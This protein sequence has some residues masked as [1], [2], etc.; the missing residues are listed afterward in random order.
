MELVYVDCAAPICIL[1]SSLTP[2][3]HLQLIVCSLSLTK[4]CCFN[5][6]SH[7]GR[8]TSRKCYA[9]S[10]LISSECNGPRLH[11]THSIC[12]ALSSLLEPCNNTEPPWH[13]SL[14]RVCTERTII[15]KQARNCSRCSDVSLGLSL[16]FRF[17]SQRLTEKARP[18]SITSS[19]SRRLWGTFTDE[20]APR[21]LSL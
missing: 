10:V 21:C 3:R 14:N 20:V 17:T 18:A 8:A 1:D 13:A 15:E 5:F 9:I 6:T 7:A 16:R 2:K 19:S 4:K 11:L 12:T